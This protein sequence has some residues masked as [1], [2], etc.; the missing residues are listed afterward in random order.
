M[1]ES[2]E[3]LAR[4]QSLFREVNEAIEEVVAGTGNVVQ[5]V[6]ECSDKECVA[7][8]KL[9]LA[10]YERIR[11]DGTWFFVKTGHNIPEIERIIS[12]DE[13]YVV[14]EKIVAEEELEAED[15]R[16]ED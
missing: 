16:S 12:Q 4:N 14:V 9:Q 8:V 10:E 11:A 5:F 1:S 13:G 6:C 7:T 2:H 15:P 3:R